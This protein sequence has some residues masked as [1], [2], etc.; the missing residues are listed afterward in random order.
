MSLKNLITPIDRRWQESLPADIYHADPTSIS[1][2]GLRKILKSPATFRAYLEGPRKPPTPEM[3]F[4]TIAHKRILEGP[5]FLKT[6][7]VMPDFATGLCDDNGKPYDKPRGSKKY[8]EKVAEWEKENEGKISVTQEQF[9]DLQYMVESIVEHPDAAA[10]LSKGVTEISGF[11]A[12][13][14]TS[15]NCR[16]RPDF[17]NFDLMAFVDLKTTGDCTDRKFSRTIVDWRYDFQMAMYGAGIEL[18]CEKPVEFYTF[19]V[20]ERE[21]P[22]ECA[23]Y[24]CD[25][26]IIERGL[27]DYRK[28]LKT[29]R[30]C[31]DADH[32]PRWQKGLQN[33]SLPYWE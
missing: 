1:S 29:L 15:V 27:K 10:L 24:T 18:L 22:F 16:I 20:M 9:D 25:Q 23:V 5:E 3:E 13:P 32:W 11:Y 4:G 14:D 8:K 7:V 17:I 21:R 12:D 19:I 6:Y 30:E 31:I 28:A 33:I 26:T 2:S